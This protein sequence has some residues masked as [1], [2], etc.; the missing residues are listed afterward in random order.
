MVFEGKDEKL[1][2]LFSWVYANLVLFYS[3]LNSATNIF[4]D[5]K[6]ANEALLFLQHQM[7]EDGHHLYHC[8][9]WKSTHFLK[10]SLTSAHN[11][12]S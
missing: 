4:F 7:G 1:P 3:G 12:S 8:Q 9:N 10:I 6:H 5:E 11:L 2:L